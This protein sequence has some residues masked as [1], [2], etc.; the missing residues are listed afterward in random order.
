[1]DPLYESPLMAGLVRIYPYCKRLL[2]QSPWLHQ[3]L[4]G[5]QRLVLLTSLF[6]GR[7]TMT[8]L[9]EAIVCS[10]EQATRA[11]T[12]L[13]QQGLLCRSYNPDHRIH[14]YIQLTDRGTALLHRQLEHSTAALRARFSALSN[15]QQQ[16]LM[17]AFSTIYQFLTQDTPAVPENQGGTP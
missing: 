13:V 14:V 8:Q 17:D 12:P 9:S 4:T 5:T 16:E 6:S 3:N 15:T 1:M 7:M 10:K 2:L 11:V